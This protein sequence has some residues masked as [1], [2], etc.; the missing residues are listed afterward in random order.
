MTLSNATMANYAFLKDMY[1][2]P[3]FPNDLVQQGEAILVD[4]CLALERNPPADLA[5]LYALTHAATEC[6]NDLQEAFEERGSEIETAA[7]EAIA[8]DFDAIAKAYGFAE[9]DVEELIA[10]RDW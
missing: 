10:P 3:Y 6:F 8:Q 4:V 9:A 5:G 7:R 2:D 1:R